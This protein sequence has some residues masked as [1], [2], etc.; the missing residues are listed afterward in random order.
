MASGSTQ[1][2]A[3]DG[4]ELSHPITI[5]RGKISRIY[6]VVAYPT[7]LT[8]KTTNGFADGTT[9]PDPKAIKRCRWHTAGIIR[10]PVNPKTNLSYEARPALDELEVTL[11]CLLE[12][13]HK[14]QLAKLS[15]EI[16]GSEFTGC[17]KN[18]ATTQKN[19]SI[20]K[21]PAH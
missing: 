13:S 11:E 7:Q 18:V 6:Q 5:K 21:K 1:D 20:L 12:E 9:T 17:G 19:Q 15:E 16:Y 10:F 3:L 2:L 8:R 4:A 14:Q